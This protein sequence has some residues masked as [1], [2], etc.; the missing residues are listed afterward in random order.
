MK[1]QLYK[2]KPLEWVMKPESKIGIVAWDVS[3]NVRCFVVHERWG[4]GFSCVYAGAHYM[5]LPTIDDAIALIEAERM[6]IL[7]A[8][9]EPVDG[10]GDG[11]ERP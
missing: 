7:M 4:G 6:K 3:Q 5:S 11:K 9:L 2:I 10:A 1:E 8:A